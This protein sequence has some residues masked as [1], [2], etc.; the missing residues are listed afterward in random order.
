MAEL[1][2]PLESER[3][4]FCGE[5]LSNLAVILLSP[6]STCRNS[7]LSVLRFNKIVSF[8]KNRD[9]RKEHARLSR[10]Y[11][12]CARCVCLFAYSF[13]GYYEA[14]HVCHIE[15]PFYDG[16]DTCGDG[17]FPFSSDQTFAIFSRS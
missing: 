3:A 15:L 2:T 11:S 13:R 5:M 7:A 9:V 8:D 6:P 12:E 1:F 16:A 10:F 14:E 17:D 4:Q